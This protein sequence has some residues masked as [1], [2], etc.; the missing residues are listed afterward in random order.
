[1]RAN[2]SRYGTPDYHFTNYLVEFLFK[3]NLAMTNALILW[4]NEIYVS[5]R[6]FKYWFFCICFDYFL[7]Y[8]SLCSIVKSCIPLYS[9]VREESESREWK[10]HKICSKSFR[11]LNLTFDSYPSFS[12]FLSPRVEGENRAPLKQKGKRVRVVLRPF[13]GEGGGGRR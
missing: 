5:I 10:S 11:A 8:N 2:I 1:M 3:R 4:I 7:H 9:F 12:S 6:S 13:A